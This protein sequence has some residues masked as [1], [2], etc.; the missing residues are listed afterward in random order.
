ML[1]VERKHLQFALPYV[2]RYL[3]SDNYRKYPIYRR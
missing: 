2:E 3:E 1:L